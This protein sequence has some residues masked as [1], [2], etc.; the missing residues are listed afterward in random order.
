MRGKAITTSQFISYFCAGMTPT[1]GKQN[2]APILHDWSNRFLTLS[3]AGILF[4][5]LYPF[6]FS[7][8]PKPYSHSPLLLGHASS[9]DAT[10]ILLNLLLFFPFGFG[11]AYKL[12]R[13]K[14]WES[15]VVHT[16][17]IGTFFSY[18][19]ELLQLYIPQ[20]ASGWEDVFTN[21]AG[22]V[23]GFLTFVLLG[24]LVLR[25]L[26][27]MEEFVQSRTTSGALTLGLI[28]YFGMCCI[29]FISVLGPGTVLASYFRY[30]GQTELKGFIFSYYALVFCPAGTWLGM[31]L[32]KSFIR[33][34]GLFATLLAGGLTV[35][36]APAALE[37]IAGRVRNR[38]FLF[39]NFGLSVA[40]MALGFCWSK[41][42]GAYTAA[43]SANPP[44]TSRTGVL[45]QMARWW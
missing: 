17:A 19:I 12:L 41:A 27:Q 26:S 6:E 38:P 22:A 32:T 9:G 3:I 39:S 31:G 20:R 21:T 5:T 16:A 25:M 33:R 1:K 29:A 42:D 4:L 15:A 35:I 34:F 13:T 7:R 28:A 2:A 11:L 10:Y 24:P 18:S 14:R 40:M 44:R 23:V 37:W 43:K 30:V 45:R 36:G 8:H